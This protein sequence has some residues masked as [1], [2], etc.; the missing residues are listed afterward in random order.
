MIENPIL[1]DSIENFV[2]KRA[3]ALAH[4]VLKN[5]P[6]GG[7]QPFSELPATIPCDER[8]RALPFPAQKI[9]H[10]LVPFPRP[11]M[12]PSNSCEGYA[13]HQF[14]VGPPYGKK[15]FFLRRVDELLVMSGTIQNFPI[16][17]K[18]S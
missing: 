11:I 6:F 10:Y 9:K 17:L 12:L 2:Q 15:I 8:L 16:F 13:V 1:S 7:V 18:K 14:T 3:L 5:W 4:H